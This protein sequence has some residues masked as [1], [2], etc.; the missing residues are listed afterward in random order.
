MKYQ[1]F[2]VTTVAIDQRNWSQES[3]KLIASIGQDNMVK[4]WD[5]NTLNQKLANSAH[6][7]SK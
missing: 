2:R 6:R 7:V 1:I 4:V 3:H 5:A